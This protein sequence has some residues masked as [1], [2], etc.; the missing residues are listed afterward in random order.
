MQ[1]KAYRAPS[2]QADA[3]IDLADRERARLISRDIF[4]IKDREMSLCTV[5]SK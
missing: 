1:T 4:Y 5:V 3:V 2:N